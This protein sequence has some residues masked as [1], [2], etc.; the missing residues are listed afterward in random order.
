MTTIK[1]AVQYE[2]RE[3]MQCCSYPQSNDVECLDEDTG[4]EDDTQRFVTRGFCIIKTIILVVTPLLSGGGG[5][6]GRDEESH[7]D[8]ELRCVP[9][10]K[11]SS[12][13]HSFEPSTL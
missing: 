11:L 5:Q 13:L 10:S 9:K 6:T 3:N 12:L 2:R 1:T 4:K 7:H 8:E